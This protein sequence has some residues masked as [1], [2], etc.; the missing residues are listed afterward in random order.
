MAVL[1]D[2]SRLRRL[3]LRYAMYVSSS[4]NDL[5]CILDP[6][7]LKIKE[8]DKAKSKW[9]LLFHYYESDKDS[10]IPSDEDTSL[11]GHESHLHRV[12]GH[13]IAAR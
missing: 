6:H 13:R 9:L 11:R 5:S 7:N 10:W 2:I 8:N 1:G 4:K 12:S 3:L